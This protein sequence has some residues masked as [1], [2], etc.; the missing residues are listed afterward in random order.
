MGWFASMTT[1]E[2]ISKVK[3]YNWQ[4]NFYD[5]IIRNKKDYIRISNYI[6][7]NPSKWDE[8]RFNKN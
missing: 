6:N 7:N 8:D 4:R 2:Y 3:Q 5:H 1:N